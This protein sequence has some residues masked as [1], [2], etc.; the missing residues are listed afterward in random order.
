MKH[1]FAVVISWETLN[2]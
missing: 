1:N 2:Y